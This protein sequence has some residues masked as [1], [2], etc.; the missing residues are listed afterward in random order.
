[1]TPRAR[2]GP[3][4]SPKMVLGNTTYV[5]MCGCV[6]PKARTLLAWLVLQ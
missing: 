5:A 6:S 3:A 1:M 4:D 2:M